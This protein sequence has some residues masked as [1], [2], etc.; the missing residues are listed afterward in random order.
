[1]KR[2]VLKGSK[3]EEPDKSK[4][5]LELD[6]K[7]KPGVA[8]GLKVLNSTFL[9]L[10]IGIT[11]STYGYSRIIIPKDVKFLMWLVWNTRSCKYISRKGLWGDGA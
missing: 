1:M 9:F 4:K 5:Q 10:A 8:S 2:I 6:K 11:I 3:M 7:E